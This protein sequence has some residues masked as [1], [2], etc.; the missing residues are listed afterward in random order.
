MLVEFLS[1]ENMD[2]DTKINYLSCL[3]R[4]IIVIC[5]LVYYRWYFCLHVQTLCKIQNGV[6]IYIC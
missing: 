1:V 5:W 3:L 4:N 6:Y 2:I